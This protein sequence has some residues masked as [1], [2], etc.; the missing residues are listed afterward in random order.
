MCWKMMF[1]LAAPLGR[2][3][4]AAGAMVALFWRLACSISFCEGACRIGVEAMA[5]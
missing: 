5:E 2:G 3:T 4:G 1:G